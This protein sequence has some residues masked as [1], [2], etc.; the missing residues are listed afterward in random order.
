MI[1][2]DKVVKSYDG[3][4]AVDGLSFTVGR[5]EVF[6]LLGPNGAGK[7][8]AIEC[9][10]GLRTP[11]SGR[12]EVLGL[13]PSVDRREFTARVA[14]QPQAASIFEHLTVRESLVLFASFHRAPRA[15]DDVVEEIGLADSVN[16]RSSNLSG[17]QMRRLLLGVALVG[18]PDVIV[19]DEPSAGL[20]PAARQ[21]L[22]RLIRTLREKNTTVLL[23]T[24]H[25][26]EASELCDRVAIVVDGGLAEIGTPRELVERFSRMSTL[27]FSVTSKTTV[28]RIQELVASDALVIDERDDRIDVSVETAEPDDV[29]RR[30]T[31]ATDVHA[32][33]FNVRSASLEEVFLEVSEDQSPE[34]RRKASRRRRGAT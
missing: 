27:T 17:G 11:T 21:T 18:D 2:V 14:V 8:T 22:W 32:R 26:D 10:V 7:T 28:E 31:F 4:N 30:L 6:G 25:M 15:V 20:D 5:G 34:R 33:A 23:S 16:V 24:H 19:L 9:I 13:D 12:I 29:I 3:F 1:T